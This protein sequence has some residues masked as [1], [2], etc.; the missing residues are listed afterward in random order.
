MWVGSRLAVARAALALAVTAVLL[1]ALVVPANATGIE[2]ERSYSEGRKDEAIRLLRK[3]AWQENDIFAQLRLGDIYSAKRGDDK[4]YKDTVEAFVWYFIASRNPNAMEYLHVDPAAQATVDSI[5]AAEREARKIYSSLL[6]DE[7]ADARNR[8]VYIHACRGG[9]GHLKLGMFYDP[10]VAERTGL[11]GRGIRPSSV[12]RPIIRPF[13]QQRHIAPAGGP[14][15]G[16]LEKGDHS[17]GRNG[18]WPVDMCRE[19]NW[20]GWL[21]GEPAICGAPDFRDSTAAI[22]TASP[23]EALMHYNLALRDRHPFAQKF[24]DAL[25]SYVGGGAEEGG[26]APPPGPARRGARPPEVRPPGV[27]SEGDDIDYIAKGKARR[28]L[29]PFEY[30]ASETRDGGETLSG[31]VHTDECPMSAERARAVALGDR[32]IS[33]S[34][35]MDML[36]FLNF[37]RADGLPASVAVKKFQ[38]FVGEEETGQLTGLQ[39]VRLFQIAATRGYVRAQRCLGIMYVKGIGVVKDFVRAERWLLS[40]ANQGDGEAMYALSELYTQGADGVEKLEDKANRY[41]Q[42]AAVAG[43]SPAKAEF[44]RLLETAPVRAEEQAPVVDEDAQPVEAEE[45]AK[46]EPAPRRTERQRV[47]ERK[48]ER[49]RRPVRR[50]RPADDGPF[51]VE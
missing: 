33:P 44:L 41:R 40:A 31:L 17:N 20:W 43:F 34:I 2:G 46:A 13:G 28:W 42:G 14:S 21:Y 18:R 37:N 36:K 30:Y 19:S 15:G 9:G 48:P 25:K 51:Q 3:A 10:V 7:R 32:V 11:E 16:S 45:P 39:T 38:D 29:S 24:I 26:E 4:L 49:P 1:G 35:R 5:A 8:I 6:Q 27:K 47:R 23:V 12:I 50:T 22:F